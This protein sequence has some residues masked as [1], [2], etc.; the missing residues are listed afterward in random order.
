MSV[1]PA[2]QPLKLRHLIQ[3]VAGGGTDLQKVLEKSFEWEHARQ[4]ELGK[5][6]LAVAS[7]LTVVVAAALASKQFDANAGAFGF[8]YSQIAFTASGFFTFA[9]LAAFYRARAIHKR[10]LLTSSVLA[11]LV[12]IQPFLQRLRREGHL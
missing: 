9:G 11:T 8:T 5:W 3:L 6:L 12:E 7:S 4:L 10:F 1:L 2:E